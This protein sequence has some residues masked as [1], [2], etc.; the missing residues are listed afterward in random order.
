M[1]L[2][3]YWAKF[4]NKDLSFKEETNTNT[5]FSLYNWNILRIVINWNVLDLKLKIAR[6]RFSLGTTRH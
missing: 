1:L 5:D 3:E 2:H 4:L 6:P